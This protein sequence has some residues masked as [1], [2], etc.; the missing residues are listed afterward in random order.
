MPA[1][2]TGV[3]KTYDPVFYGNARVEGTQ[4]RVAL[5]VEWYQKASE[6]GDEEG[7]N[8]LAELEAWLER[9]AFRGNEE[10]RSLLEQ[11]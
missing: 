1:A 6:G 7:M 5:A 4:P 3:G 2:A 9:A 10:A 11:R 8:R